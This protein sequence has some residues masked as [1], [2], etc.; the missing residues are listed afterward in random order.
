MVAPAAV[1]DSYF[2]P[3]RKPFSVR[4]SYYHFIVI[5][6]DMH[7]NIIHKQGVAWGL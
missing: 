6:N 7:A 1:L 5:I 3:Y 4:F 2:R